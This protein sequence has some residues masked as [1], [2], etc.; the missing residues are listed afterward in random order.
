M[1]HIS[2]SAMKKLEVSP[3]FELGSLDFFFFFFLNFLVNLFSV[4]L[5]FYF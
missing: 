1:G 4:H 5:Q 3:R 2:Q